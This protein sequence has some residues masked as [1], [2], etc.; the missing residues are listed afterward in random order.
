VTVHRVIHLVEPTRAGALSK[1]QHNAALVQALFGQICAAIRH[2]SASKGLVHCP[3]DF[4]ISYTGTFY[5]NRQPLAKFVYSASGCQTVSLTA[6]G[7]TRTTL[8]LGGASAAAPKLQAAMAAV[9]EVPRLAIAQPVSAS[10]A[11]K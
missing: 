3:A 5:D 4:G 8:M 7:T 6:D 11:T 1:T 10:G 2:P 9:L